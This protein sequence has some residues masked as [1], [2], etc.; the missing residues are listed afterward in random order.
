[1]LRLLTLLLKD[2]IEEDPLLFEDRFLF[3]SKHGQGHLMVYV[4]IAAHCD[5]PFLNE[6]QTFVFVGVFCFVFK[7]YF[8][9]IFPYSARR[10]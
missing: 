2:V 10:L 5:T 1:M 6:R 9:Q 8:G 7:G 4:K 3:I